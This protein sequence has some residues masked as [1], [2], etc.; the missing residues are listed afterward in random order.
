MGSFDTVLTLAGITYGV[1]LILATFINHK[2]LEAFR[3]DALIMR[4]P[5]QSSRGLNLVCGLAIIGYNV[6]TL[7]W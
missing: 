6:Y 5:S 7:V 4:N 3:I 1:I 2:A